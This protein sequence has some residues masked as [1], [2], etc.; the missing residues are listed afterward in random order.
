MPR[1]SKYRLGNFELLK[2]LAMVN[3]RQKM[4]RRPINVL[5]YLTLN[6]IESLADYYGIKFS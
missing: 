1:A 3:R 2:D 4:V 6:K 5:E